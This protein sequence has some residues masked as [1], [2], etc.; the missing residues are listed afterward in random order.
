MKS[1]KLS[2][3]KKLMYMKDAEIIKFLRRNPVFAVEFLYGIKL[4]DSQKYALQMAWNGTYV[5]L[6]CSRNFGKSLLAGII[7]MLRSHL[8]PNH[9]A[10]IISNSGAQAMETFMKME[11]MALQRIESM[12]RL[13]EVFYGEIVKSGTGNG[14]V[15]DKAGYRCEL[16]NGS[17]IYTLNSVPDNIRG[18]RSNLNVWDEASFCSDELIDATEPFLTQDSDF[19]L[20]ADE[21]F[22]E[23]A[24][25]TYDQDAQRENIPNMR[26][27]LS[28]AGDIQS[29]HALKY[30]DYA[31][32]MVAGDTRYFVMDVPCELPLNPMVDGNIVKPLLSQTEI[33]DAM[34]LNP[35]KAQREYYNK[36]QADGGVTQMIRWAQ[37][38]RNEDF[39]LPKMCSAN[40]DE[41]FAFA[42]DPARRMDNS[43]VSVMEIYEDEDRGLCG[44]IVNCTNLIDLGKKRKIPMK[45][46]DQIKYV[47]QMLVDYNGK[48]PDYI[49]IEELLIDAGA[50]GG[51]V[52]AVAD[53][54]LDDWV[55]KN[56]DKHCGI[57]DKEYGIYTE[58]IIN[59]PN[60]WGGLNLVS[61][62]KWRSIMCTELEELMQLDV[63]KFPREYNGKSQITLEDG[64]SYSLSLEEQVAL[65]N[66]DIMKSEV[67]SIHKTYNPQ[68]G[69]TAYALP[70]EKERRMHDDRFYTLLMLAH[71]LYGIR[72]EADMSK[73]RK[74]KKKNI[75]QFQFYN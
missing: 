35:D 12:P 15:H 2:S 36:F 66:I 44:R 61:P 31:K 24:I 60:A 70:K 65:I 53:N 27:F 7:V 29:K 3:R 22:G 30:W 14:F 55:G 74:K 51:G 63:I 19:K 1:S 56:G 75:S 18:K 21:T 48:A 34:R 59:Y 57:I 54:M 16:F 38:R 28:S 23:E 52:N 6:T 33:D 20:A 62:I 13:T 4:M 41:K 39:L 68:S 17:K 26:V 25:N 64:T 9:R 42:F 58:E 8:Y 46:P 43:P 45:T 67:T 47:Q 50:G 40:L 32:K 10:Y 11:D 49:N 69:K 73:S 5:N 37:I 72:R 71:Y